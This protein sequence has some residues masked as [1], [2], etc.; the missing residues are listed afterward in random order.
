M[1]QELIGFYVNTAQAANQQ[2]N[3]AA[4]SKYSRLAL[5]LA[6][7]IP[8]SWYNL[9]I[10]EGGLGNERAAMD[11]FEQARIRTADSAVAQNDIG[12]RLLEL[13]A[14]KEAAQC[15]EQAL[16][17]QPDYAAAHANYASLLRAQDRL[18]EAEKHLLIAVNLQPDAAV[19]LTNLG[20][21]YLL[22]KLYD[23]AVAACRKALEI[24]PRMVQAWIN[25]GN[26]L[27]ANNQFNEA[28]EACNKALELDAN[29]GEA[30]G[31]LGGLRYKQD[32]L[33]EAELAC[34]RD[35][36]LSPK[37]SAAW[38]QLGRVL[39]R[40]K[41]GKEAVEAFRQAYALNPREDY[42]LGDLLNVSL[43]LCD[44]TET[45]SVKAKLPSAMEV[46]RKVV[47]PMTVILSSDDAILQLKAA[48]DFTSK[49]YPSRSRMSGAQAHG[50]SNKIRLAFLSAD[51]KTHPVSQLIVELLE[52]FDR[53][54][55]EVLGFSFSPDSQDPL[56]RR[57]E[58]A[59]DHFCDLRGISDSDACQLIRKSNVDIAVN[60]GGY[61]EG[62]RAGIFA[63]R[64]A[65]IQV[66]YLG[67][68]GTM[69]ADYIDYLITDKTV[70]PPGSEVF[71]TEKLAYLPNCFMPYDR[72]QKISDRVFTR[73][74]FSLP[75]S[76]FVFC[77]F[78]NHNKINSEVFDVW[79]RLLGQLPGS[80][81][82]LSNGSQTI[83][84][85]LAMEAS[86]RGIDPARII[87]APR[88]ES[89][90][91]HLARYRLADL[92]I[93]TF[94][95]NA[96]TTACD[97]LWAGIPVLTCMGQSF[98]SRVAGSLLHTVGLPEL[99]TS[100]LDEY[101]VLALELA[102]NPARLSTLRQKL[103]DTRLTS[104]L[105]DTQRLA[106]DI[107]RLCTTM[108]ERC[109]AGLNPKSIDGP[110]SISPTGNCS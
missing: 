94:P 92:F 31:A 65:P 55:F 82:W 19:L 80:V 5:A 24:D 101:E 28:A 41:R 91:D 68:P 3:F 109:Q 43:G 11:A 67:Y 110:S 12:L 97:A 90:A 2:H 52:T 60:L 108:Y 39:D 29:C 88:L 98:A 76:G 59:F 45:E 33:D 57:I 70:C 44:W 105:F 93:D 1:S 21:V 27:Q 53:S 6:P 73:Q 42:V 64:A 56:R 81:L 89:M 69:G 15:L 25:L 54:R 74:D 87:Y 51:F 50:A 100:S 37:N 17:I 106:K 85:N 104:P 84:D 99:V 61:T 102:R 40:Q 23:E 63:L 16:A 95:Y 75:D 62:H 30:W 10:A 47:W 86:A 4:A 78:N 66:S 13:R 22:R 38:A 26:A 72:T 32:L 20:G 71:F 49:M 18:E 79:M 9:G 46:N 107:E 14:Y 96:H 8:E 7:D 77:C 48:Q 36:A 34:R 35:V 58:K 83:K 103:A